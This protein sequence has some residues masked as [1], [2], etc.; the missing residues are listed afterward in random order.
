MKSASLTSIE[1]QMTRHAAVRPTQ[2]PVRPDFLHVVTAG[3]LEE[4]KQAIV[5]RS[6]PLDFETKLMRLAQGDL[7]HRFVE[8]SCRLFA[9]LLLAVQDEM[10]GASKA[11]CER[12]LRVL[13]Y[14]RKDDDLVAD[15]K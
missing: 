1:Q 9:V 2:T 8:R 12:L 6:L 14:V 10:F 11:D 13:A 3:E 5:R 15:Y 7:T 4:L